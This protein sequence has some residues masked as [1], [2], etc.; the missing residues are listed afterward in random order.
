MKNSIEILKERYS[1]NIAASEKATAEI[2]AIESKLH[3]MQK[4]A[5]SIAASGD[6]ELY[7]EAKKR[8]DEQ[9]TLLEVK[10]AVKES[11][12]NNGIT[13][14]EI[15]DAWK[16]Y[17]ANAMRE[18]NDA[19]SKYK[20]MRVELCNQ[21]L[22]LVKKQ[23]EM[24]QVRDMCNDMCGGS[25]DLS[26]GSLTTD[27]LQYDQDYFYRCGIYDLNKSTAIGTVLK[28]N[29]ASELIAEM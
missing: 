15:S 20:K 8:I 13:S 23:N 19:I 6:V 25:I 22:E 18:M 28:L 5:A 21:F 4:E 27:N 14:A 26:I 24:L 7:K 9:K 1:Q 3:E 2:A 10:K 12:G 29:N 16:Q 17:S 11:N